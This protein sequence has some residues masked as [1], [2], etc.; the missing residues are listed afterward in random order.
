M[1]EN[2]LTEFSRLHDKTLR[3]LRTLPLAA[4]KGRFATEE[5]RL[6]SQANPNLAAGSSDYRGESHY[7]FC[8]QDQ[9]CT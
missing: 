3:S 2:R 6:F 5:R 4:T 8:L 9:S 7:L 1:K